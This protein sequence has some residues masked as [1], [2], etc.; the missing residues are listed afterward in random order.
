M[1]MICFAWKHP[2]VNA[3][4]QFASLTFHLHMERNKLNMDWREAKKQ[5]LHEITRHPFC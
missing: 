5:L 2:N 3:L 4:E 1:S